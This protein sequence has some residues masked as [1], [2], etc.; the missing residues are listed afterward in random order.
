MYI[1][2]ATDVTDRTQ[3]Q[4]ILWKKKQTLH[5]VPLQK[6]IQIKSPIHLRR[7]ETLALYMGN[8]GELCT[9]PV[10]T[11]TTAPYI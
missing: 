4:S 9:V 1:C 10:A 6:N 8:E 7:S 2:I 5:R 11:D 3:F